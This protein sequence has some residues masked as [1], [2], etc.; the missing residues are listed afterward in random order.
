MK[1][2]FLDEGEATLV[3]VEDVL[4]PVV[5]TTQYE[6]GNTVHRKNVTDLTEMYITIQNYTERETVKC[7][8][9]DASR[10]N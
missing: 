5:N 1:T 8:L 7:K 3:V 10:G 6:K 2:E 4:T 9:E